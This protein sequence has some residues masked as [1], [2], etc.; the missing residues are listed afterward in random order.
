MHLADNAQMEDHSLRYTPTWSP[1]MVFLSCLVGLSAM[2]GY[3]LDAAFVNDFG[4]GNSLLGFAIASIV[5][6][7][8]AIVIAFAIARKH[9]DIDLLTRGSGFGYLGSTVT[10]LVY[11]TYTW[12][13]LAFEGAIMAQAVTALSGLDVHL[14]YVAVSVVMVPLTLYGMS[15][16]AK[17]QAWTWPA[18][19]VLIGWPWSRPRRRRR[20]ASTCSTPSRRAGWV[21]A[22]VGS[23]HGRSWIR[24]VRGGG[25]LRL[26]AAC[27]LRG[28]AGD[29]GRGGAAHEPVHN[30]LP[31][32]HR[33]PHGGAGLPRWSP[34]W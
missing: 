15:F 13:F 12:I 2:A 6:L 17:F 30:R 23:D 20:R 32:P 7:P 28:H 33:Q 8:L 31:A 1:L 3:A 24:R 4:F 18:W 16:S 26:D 9:I 25:L 29:G 34:T 19:V 11:A 22:P 27:R 10:S 5:T 14:S 21:W